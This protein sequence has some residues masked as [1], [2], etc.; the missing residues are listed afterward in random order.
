[1]VQKNPARKPPENIFKT[2]KI[3]GFQLPTSTGFIGRIPA[4]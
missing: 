1:M 2:L 4:I 3:M